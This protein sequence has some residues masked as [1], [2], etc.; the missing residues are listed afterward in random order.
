V[1]LTLPPLNVSNELQTSVL[2]T[3]C[4]EN[5][6]KNVRRHIGKVCRWR[7][8]T[9]Q[10]DRWL[11]SG[12]ILAS[13]GFRRIVGHKPELV[14]ALHDQCVAVVHRKDGS[15]IRVVPIK[16][17]AGNIGKQARPGDLPPHSPQPVPGR[18]ARTRIK[19][20]LSMVRKNASPSVH[21]IW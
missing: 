19:N 14:R 6:F 4:I 7:E 10:A 11:A 18:G 21:P 5:A 8:S 20:G 2:S 12:L 16:V 1:L 15:R 13:K 9:D 3:N 17:R